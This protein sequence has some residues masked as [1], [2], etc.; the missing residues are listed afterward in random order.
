MHKFSV[1]KAQA[2]IDRGEVPSRTRDFMSYIT[3]PGKKDQGMT[4]QEQIAIAPLLIM[5]GSETT[6]TALSG[7]MFLL[8]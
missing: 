7:F 4:K 1:A 8:G 3:R 2:C 6:A 5:A